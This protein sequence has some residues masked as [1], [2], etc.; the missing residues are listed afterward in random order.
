MSVRA[1]GGE[2]N[3][4]L[5]VLNASWFRV[6]LVS[7]CFSPSIGMIN[8]KLFFLGLV[9]SRHLADCVAKKLATK[10]FFLAIHILW[11]HIMIIYIFIHHC[12]VCIDV[13]TF[14]SICGALARAKAQRIST[15]SARK[16]PP[17]WRANTIRRDLVPQRGGPAREMQFTNATE[18]LQ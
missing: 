16:Q 18:K 4:W 17:S 13:C 15:V 6:L 5:S 9:H 2:K 11:T 8:A 10:H 1:D 12:L 14:F 7:P 3:S